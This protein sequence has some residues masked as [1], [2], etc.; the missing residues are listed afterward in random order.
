MEITFRSLAEAEPGAA[1][2]T[3][4]REGWPGWCAWQRSRRS[5]GGPTPGACRAALA[6]HMPELIPAWRR[7]VRQVGADDEAARFLTFWCPPR[8]LGHCSQAV[9]GGRQPSLVRN[10]D[11]DPRLS[12]RTLLHTGWLG[13]QVAGMVDGMSGLADGMNEDGLVV[14]LAYGGRQVV[15]CGFGIPIVVRYLLETC[16]RVSEALDT[17]ARLPHH[18]SYNLALLDRAGTHA[19]VFVA[20]DRDPVVSHRR[21]STNHQQFI[22]DPAHA[23]FCDTL[24]RAACLDALLAGEGVSAE[25][26]VA[27]F[28]A[29]PLFARQYRA[30]FGTVYT[31]HYEPARSSVSLH[32]P[33]AESLT[34]DLMAPAP[35]ERIVRYDIGGDSGC[36]GPGDD[37]IQTLPAD[38]RAWITRWW[39]PTPVQANVGWSGAGG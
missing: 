25:A 23:S 6:R 21:F 27:A 28:Q 16:T 18:M 33:T 38:L 35:S 19:T 10:Y 4:F 29:P 22:E 5:G 14:S 39:S 8:Y 26:L 32:W 3:V 17:L 13:K 15:G 7:L 36:V 2:E 9:I 31:A 20:P 11:L 34:H 24:G 12:E 30:G 1:W 37:W